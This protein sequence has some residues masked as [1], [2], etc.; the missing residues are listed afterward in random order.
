[1]KNKTLLI[2]ALMSAFAIGT[3]YAG[4]KCRGCNGTGWRG[5]VKCIQCGGDGET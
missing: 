3:V 4:F 5:Q 1:M 2:V